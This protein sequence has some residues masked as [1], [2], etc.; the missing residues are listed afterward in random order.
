MRSA[1]IAIL[2]LLMAGGSVALVVAAEGDIA[3]APAPVGAEDLLQR[4]IAVQRGLTTIS[5][6]FTQ[7]TVRV[8]DP[9]LDSD[10]YHARFDLMHPDKYNIIY[11]KP[12]DDEYRLRYCS[13]GSNR[14]RQEQLFADGKPDTEVQ[15]V[16]KATDDDAM[17][18]ITALFRLDPV[19]ITRDF[20]ITPQPNGD[21]WTVLLVPREPGLAEK[22]KGIEVDLDP[23][24][25]TKGVRIDDARGNRILITI[26]EAVYNPVLPPET[27]T[28]PPTP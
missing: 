6:R 15:P 20:T 26:E 18:R 16:A 4:V 1:A 17:A 14:G 9:E 5:G 11:T 7:K 12:G 28:V 27:F 24:L 2:T 22:V 3:P 25:R 13:D 21:S 19:A 8:D 23:S 10:V